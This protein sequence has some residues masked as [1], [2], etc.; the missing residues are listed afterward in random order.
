MWNK[1]IGLVRSPT[2]GLQLDTLQK[3]EDSRIGSP[4]S[5]HSM[6]RARDYS[7]DIIDTHRHSLEKEHSL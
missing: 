5:P 1:F 7:I 3:P 4:R 6:R 2:P